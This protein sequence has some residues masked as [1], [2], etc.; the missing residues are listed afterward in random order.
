[1]NTERELLRD[2]DFMSHRPGPLQE[3]VQYELLAQPLL[4]SA[5]EH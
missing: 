1:M 2:Q 5:H 4:P 3:P